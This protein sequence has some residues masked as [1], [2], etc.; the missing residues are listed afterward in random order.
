MSLRIEAGFHHLKDTLAEV[1]AKEVEFPVGVFVTVLETKVTA[2]TAHAKVV[3][4]VMPE[5]RQRDVLDTLY[6]YRREIKEGLSKSLRLRRIPELHYVFDI[7]EAKAAVIES[8][9]NR[10]KETGEI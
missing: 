6:D 5:N 4:S 10:L 7:T 9:I 3:L 2:N 1:L 8:E